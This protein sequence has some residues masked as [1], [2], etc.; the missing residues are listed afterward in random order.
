[1]TE[2]KKSPAAEKSA[3]DILIEMQLEA[4]RQKHINPLA[5]VEDTPV[6][7][8]KNEAGVAVTHRRVFANGT[9][10]ETYS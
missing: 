6:K 4:E 1:M 5:V 8:E 2:A 10:V 7:G 3:A 9:V